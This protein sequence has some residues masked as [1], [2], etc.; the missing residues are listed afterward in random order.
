MTGLDPVIN[1]VG[2]TPG[3]LGE[4]G[5]PNALS[6]GQGNAWRVGTRIKSGHDMCTPA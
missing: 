4:Q 5:R 6:T 1:A 3:A 2:Q